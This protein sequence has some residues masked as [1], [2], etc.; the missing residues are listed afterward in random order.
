MLYQAYQAHTDFYWPLHTQVTSARLRLC[1]C[2][3]E[4]GGGGTKEQK[5][6]HARGL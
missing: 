1:G 3:S 5:V 4:K 2:D 6:F